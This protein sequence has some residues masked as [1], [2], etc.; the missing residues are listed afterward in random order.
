M[1]NAQPDD[2]GEYALAG[3][4]PKNVMPKIISNP[5]LFS[6]QFGVSPLDLA[7]E[8]L[9]DPFLNADTKLFIDPMLLKTSRNPIIRKSAQALLR[10]QLS[11]IL[12]LIIASKSETDPAWKAALGLL[13]LHE[14]RETCLGYGGSGVSGSSRPDSLKARILKTTRDVLK[15]WDY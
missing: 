12:K 5:R 1:T 10:D 6:Q 14:R 8:D 11:N 7:K 15:S 13:D 9:L 2:F 4:V 3:F